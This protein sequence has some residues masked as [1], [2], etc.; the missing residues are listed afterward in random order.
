[1]PVYERVTTIRLK[2]YHL[3]YATN[4]DT[5]SFT[6]RE[7]DCS[8]RFPS[9]ELLLSPFTLNTK[10]LANYTLPV[11]KETPQACILNPD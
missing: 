3:N 1:M 8:V 10:S 6:L 11:A 7:L 5:Y 9:K 4:T 2:I